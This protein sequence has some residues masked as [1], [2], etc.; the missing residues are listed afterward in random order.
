MATDSDFLKVTVVSCAT[1]IRQY[2]GF[3]LNMATAGFFC[4]KISSSMFFG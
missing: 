2:V 4:C 1:E 3:T